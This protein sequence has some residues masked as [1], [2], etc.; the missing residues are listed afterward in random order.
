MLVGYKALNDSA[1]MTFRCLFHVYFLIKHEKQDVLFSSYVLKI[2]S[3]ICLQIGALINFDNIEA[4]NLTKIFT[5]Q[6]K[7]NH[8]AKFSFH[9]THARL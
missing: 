1:L 2:D 3:L 4:V 6:G 8:G 5:L 9:E 7:N